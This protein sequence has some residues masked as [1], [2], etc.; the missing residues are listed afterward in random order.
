MN[1][2]RELLSCLAE[3]GMTADRVVACSHAPEHKDKRVYFC[4]SGPE[5]RYVVT[6]FGAESPAA[7]AFHKADAVVRRLLERIADTSTAKN[8]LH[9]CC[10]L[11]LDRQVCLVSRFIR[12]ALGVS[13]MSRL[14]HRDLRRLLLESSRWILAFQE[15]TVADE[16]TIDAIGAFSTRLTSWSENHGGF[17][18][19]EFFVLQ[20]AFLDA[21]EGLRGK[22]PNAT[23]HGDYCF[24]NHFFD[25]DNR[26]HVFDWELVVEED[27][28]ACDFFCNLV[29][30]ATGCRNA[31]LG[32]RSFAGLFD[33]TARRNK[34]VDL[35]Q[36]SLGVFREKYSIDS[37]EAGILFVYAYFYLLVSC[38]S[39]HAIRRRLEE[40]PRLHQILTPR[41]GKVCAAVHQPTD[42]AA[43]PLARTSR[44]TNTP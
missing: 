42:L 24:C 32:D 35:F 18:P 3:R 30:F 5:I 28:V 12:P 8:I 41:R 34:Y 1:M 9:P 40:L 19:Q 29:V 26:F 16:P 11:E 17:L 38:R 23:R 36:E 2:V 13:G 22:L 6:A 7:T 25:A 15:C 39:R 31:L 14:R 20:R 44:D 37:E 27:C 4:Y 21:W 33:A 43:D 10:C